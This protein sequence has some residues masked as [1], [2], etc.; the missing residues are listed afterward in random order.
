MHAYVHIYA[1]TCIHTWRT[2]AVRPTADAP[3]PVM[4][5]A[6]VH[7]GMHA[8]IYIYI[9][10]LH[11]YAHTCI[12]TWRTDAVRPTADAPLPVVNT[13]RGVVFS[14]YFKNCDLATPAA[15]EISVSMHACVGLC[16][17]NSV[18]TAYIFELHAYTYTESIHV[19]TDM[20]IN[21]RKTYD[22]RA[23]GR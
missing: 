13:A 14:T 5:T 9:Y 15:Q 2:D 17:C 20:R 4:H 11:I 3:L 10:I 23:A 6:Y 18:L 16:V 12:H 8:C 1:H 7:T 22:L 19:Y 21:A